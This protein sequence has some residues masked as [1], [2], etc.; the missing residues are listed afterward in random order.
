MLFI[1]TETT[2][3]DAQ[4]GCRPFMVGVSSSDTQLAYQQ[5]YWPVDP[6]T[7]LPNY[8]G[9][10][11]ARLKDLLQSDNHWCF[12]NA[13]FD[14]EMLESIGIQ[15]TKA[16]KICDT[17]VLAHLHRNDWP[18]GLKIQAK[19]LL[20][21]PDS[22][23]KELQQAVVQARRVAKKNKW[24]IAQAGLPFWPARTRG[25]W[26]KFDYWL[27][28]EKCAKYLNWDVLRTQ[29]L[30]RFFD[31]WLSKN[32]RYIPVY[33]SRMALLNV[34]MD[35]QKSGFQANRKAIIVE[36]MALERNAKEQEKRV[37]S[38]TGNINLN[39]PKQLC[40]A[41]YLPSTDRK[42]LEEHVRYIGDTEKGNAIKALLELR[43]SVKI[44]GYLQSYEKWLSPKDR[45]HARINL[46]GTRFTRQSSNDPNLHNPPR[47]IVRR[48]FGPPRG[49]WWW[50]LDFQNLE[51][52]IWAYSCKADKFI[53]AFERG[54][55]VHAIT[56]RA[57]FPDLIGLSD[58]E[59]SDKNGP[60]YEYYHLA[61]TVNFALIYG[62]E[63][64]TVDATTGRTGT[65]RLLI[66]EFPQI[67]PFTK[68]LSRELLTYGKI[69]TRYG[70]P[71]HV[72][73]SE[74]H[75]AVSAYVQG[76]AGCIMR[77]SQNRIAHY[78][79][80]QT[81]G[82]TMVNQ[83]HDEVILEV[84]EGTPLH[85]LEYIQETML[86]VGE[87]IGVPTPTDCKIIKWPHK[88]GKG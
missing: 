76:T 81:K 53:E 73:E 65:Y 13:P 64:H 25:E 61:K 72:P 67:Q 10:Q 43:S 17:Q 70:Y 26:A 3:L 52:R 69:H 21:F 6:L 86:R 80:T 36:R 45:I 33:E 75:K 82:M 32:H 77:E 68:S 58:E 1:D 78:L 49:F 50:D 27:C 9:D 12:H 71:L 59:L 39:S 56:C 31:Q 35:I 19:M 11:L 44:A 87:Q 74:P 7:R 62:A 51:L 46:T 55:S 5:F 79:K 22:D 41:L 57:I 38:F 2:G 47:A 63:E 24:M 83:I 28:P 60:Y 37:V 16:V 85:H 66:G 30:W 4:F 15:R 18:T 23:E 40:D 34:C 20:G 48:C 14:L 8:D 84:P 88:W 29:G 54:V 42:F